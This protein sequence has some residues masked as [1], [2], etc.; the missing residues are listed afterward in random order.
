MKFI[1]TREISCFGLR[2]SGNHAIL[3]WIRRQNNGCFV[4]LN[5][6]KLY[7]HKD[8][9]KSFSKATITGI[10]PLLYQREN[11]KFKRFLKYLL[12]PNV[13]YL[14]GGDTSKLEIEKLREYRLKSLLIHSYEHYCLS[15]VLGTWFEK[16]REEFLGKSQYKFDILILRDPYNTFASLIKSGEKFNNLDFIIDKWLEHAREYL[17]LSNYL[18]N[19]VSISYNQWFQNKAY[20]QKIAENLGLIFTDAG[21]NTVSV[22]GKGSSFDRVNY[23]GKASQMTVLS[24]YQDFLD[25][26]VMLKVL[27][28]Q[29]LNELSQEIFGSIV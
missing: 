11:I 28:N 4:H 9:Y 14:F 17:G 29:E 18:H 27:A 26:P 23:D 6:V 1:N 15:Q 7:T 12:D 5:D 3:N 13:E 24:R 10:N 2:R 8:P 16:K 20:R 19:R 22:V 25:H 21:I